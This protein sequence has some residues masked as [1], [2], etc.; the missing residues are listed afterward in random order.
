M[1]LCV[2]AV[3]LC[4]GALQLVQWCCM[5]LCVSAVVLHVC[6]VG[7]CAGATVLD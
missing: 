3:V 2:S 5:V 4:A 1:V 6:L 7:V